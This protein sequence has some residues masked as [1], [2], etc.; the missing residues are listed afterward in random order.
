MLLTE[1]SA[2]SM[3]RRQNKTDTQKFLTRGQN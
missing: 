2:I 3:P 1:G